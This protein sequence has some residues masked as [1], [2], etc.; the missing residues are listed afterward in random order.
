M[1]DKG[2]NCCWLIRLSKQEAMGYLPSWLHDQGYYTSYI[3]KL[4]VEVSSW[5][6]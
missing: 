2:G 6:C 5:H 1:L 4:V 3:G